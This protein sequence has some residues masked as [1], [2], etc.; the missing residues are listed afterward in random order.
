MRKSFYYSA[1]IGGRDWNSGGNLGHD[2]VNANVR[3]FMCA[4]LYPGCEISTVMDKGF[5]CSV[6]STRPFC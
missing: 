1:V 3:V 5:P 4:Q 2:P 6:C